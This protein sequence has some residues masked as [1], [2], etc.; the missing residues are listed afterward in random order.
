MPPETLTEEELRQKVADLQAEH[1]RLEKRHV[2]L[3]SERDQLR[4]AY[5][6]L[7]AQARKLELGVL[8]SGRERDLGHPEQLTLEMLAMMASGGEPPAPPPPPDKKKVRTRPTSR[9]A[10]G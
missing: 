8:G 5:L 1:D 4:R 6:D 10:R 2:E 3:L 9:V 7:L